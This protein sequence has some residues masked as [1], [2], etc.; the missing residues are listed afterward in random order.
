MRVRHDGGPDDDEPTLGD[1]IPAGELP[2]IADV[3]DALAF[4]TSAVVGYELTI[5]GAADY[6]A[7][8]KSGM[9]IAVSFGDHGDVPH[10][11]LAGTARARQRSARS[12]RMPS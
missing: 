8:S 12:A 6:L 10:L 4:E 9:A 11:G 5:D 1:D 7:A 3:A 2:R